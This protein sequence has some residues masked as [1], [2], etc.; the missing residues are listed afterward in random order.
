VDRPERRCTGNR[1]VLVPFCPARSLL[2]PN[3][4]HSRVKNPHAGHPALQISKYQG[5]M[6]KACRIYQT[7]NEAKGVLFV[8]VRL[9][10]KP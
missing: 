2:T 9:N 10:P 4:E 8:A 6:S 7:N 5:P 1:Q 3:L